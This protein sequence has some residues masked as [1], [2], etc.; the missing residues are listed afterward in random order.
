MTGEFGGGEGGVFGV[1]GEFGGGVGGVFGVTGEFG[2]GEGGVFGV[3]CEFVGGVAGGGVILGI[4]AGKFILTIS[5][6]RLG[7]V[8]IFRFCLGQKLFIN[9]KICP[10]VGSGFGFG[11]F[12]FRPRFGLSVILICFLA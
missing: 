9:G 8:I 10:S 6:L 11:V 4:G 2:G 1:T 5:G 7:G 12:V 3:T